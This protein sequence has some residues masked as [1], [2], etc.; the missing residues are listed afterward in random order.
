MKFSGITGRSKTVKNPCS[1]TD[2]IFSRDLTNFVQQLMRDRGEPIPPED[3]LDI[4]RR[5]KEAY[6]YTCADI[7]KVGLLV[8][9]PRAYGGLA[10][11]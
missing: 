10:L 8:V 2:R 3:S 7:V 5:I 11:G 9:I 1:N 6:S 4:A